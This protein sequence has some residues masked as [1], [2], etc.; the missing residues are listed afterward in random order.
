MTPLAAL[1]QM[2]CG[3]TD[4]EATAV[5]QAKGLVTWAKLAAVGTEKRSDRESIWDA[6]LANVSD[7]TDAGT[8]ER[9]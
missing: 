5:C 6:G 2:D 3:D 4:G 7:R 1:W 8:G 9:G